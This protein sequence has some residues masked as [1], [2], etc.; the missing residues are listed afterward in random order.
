[1]EFQLVTLAEGASRAGG[2]QSSHRAGG[3]IVAIIGV[4]LL[5]A[6]FLWYRYVFRLQA[7]SERVFRKAIKLPEVDYDS[8][9]PK[10]TRWLGTI[11]LAIL[12]LVCLISGLAAVVGGG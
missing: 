11:F 7:G 10:L 2:L 1:M 5:A 3:A 4:A 8:F 9:F 12:G 6:A